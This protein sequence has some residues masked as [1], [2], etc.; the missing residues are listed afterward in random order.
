M[1]SIIKKTLL[2]LGCALPVLFCALKS[3]GQTIRIVAYNI[4][5]G[6]D[7][8]EKLQLTSIADLIK[9]S[10]A[11]IVGLE[12]VDSVCKR[13]ENTDQ[14]KILAT[15]TGMHY[16]YVRHFAF[17]G[18]SYGLALLSKYPISG[19]VNNRL[20]V[21]T[22]ENGNTRAFLTATLQLSKKEQLMVGVVHLDY[23]NDDSRATQSRIIVN[24]FANKKIPVLFLGDLN[25]APDSKP[26]VNLKGLFTDTNQSGYLT[27]PSDHPKEKIDYIMVNTGHYLKTVKEPKYNVQ[28]SDHL[29]ILSDVKLI[30]K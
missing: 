14:A 17:D 28:Y 9:K 1:I 4:H 19:L 3:K 18:G 21:L 15:L 24:M 13:S 29:P 5:H 12:E 2:L 10:K 22:D 16:A 8:N 11:Q 26:I 7:I 6:C 20:P 23:R 30:F 25:A 27:F